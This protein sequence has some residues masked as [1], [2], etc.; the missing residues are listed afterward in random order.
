MVMTGIPAAIALL[1]S[2]DINFGSAT[3]TRIPAGFRANAA[4][5]SSTSIA[6]VKVSGPLISSVTPYSAAAR[7]NPACADCQY[8]K[9]ILV[10]MRKYCSDLLW[11]SHPPTKRGRAVASTTR[12]IRFSSIFIITSNEQEGRILLLK[13]E[14]WKGSS[15]E[16]HFNMK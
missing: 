2:G 9:S 6:G 1:I 5:N 14:T 12:R 10:A 11:R 4:R 15:Q 8:G 3:D 7:V 16:H 13:L